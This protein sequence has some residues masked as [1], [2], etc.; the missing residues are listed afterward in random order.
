MRD[1][2]QVEIDAPVADVA[3]LFADPTLSESWM[4]GTRY[5][6]LDGEQGAPGS[7]YRL[8]MADGGMTFTATVLSRELPAAVRLRLESDTATVDI[9]AG[10]AALGPHKTLLTSDEHFTFKGV[11]AKLFSVLARRSIRKTHR[12]QMLSFKRFAER[13][14]VGGAA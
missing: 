4:Q 12:E 1:V 13:E 3:R 10:F 5:Q 6:P 2:V 9:R 14:G 7:T 11:A 8:V